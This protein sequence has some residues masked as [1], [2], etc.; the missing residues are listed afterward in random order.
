MQ[1]S[2]VEQIR[3]TRALG[4]IVKLLRLDAIW[5]QA[6]DHTGISSAEEVS[7]INDISGEMDRL[8]AELPELAAW[9]RDII[10]R[11]PAAFE[12]SVERIIEGHPRSDG[13]SA[14]HERLIKN[15]HALNLFHSAADAA[16]DI[17]RTERADI[18]AKVK[19]IN[20]GGQAEGDLSQ[21]G[22]CALAGIGLGLT[23]VAIATAGGASVLL[24]ASLVLDIAEASE[25]F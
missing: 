25:C 4:D 2:L 19:R 20:N 10:S 16:E 11:D 15:S 14:L 6:L 21:S 9:T 17:S 12:K 3:A 18:A 22:R 1:A 7:A 8:L 23:A 5:T 24:S 13:R